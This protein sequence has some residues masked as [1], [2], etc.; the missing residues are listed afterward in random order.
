MPPLIFAFLYATHTAGRTA[1]SGSR[2]WRAVPACH[3]LTVFRQGA[4]VDGLSQRHL[5]CHEER[6]EGGLSWS[7]QSQRQRRSARQWTFHRYLKCDQSELSPSLLRK[8]C[9][10]GLE[11]QPLDLWSGRPGN[12]QAD[13]AYHS[14]WQQ[15]LPISSEEH[16]ARLAS[17]LLPGS[18]VMC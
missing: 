18:H 16:L 5:R 17:L 14:A 10:L 6:S 15:Q 2:R 12:G 13:S 4:A 11:G 8:V 7:F 1:H 3:C 9:G